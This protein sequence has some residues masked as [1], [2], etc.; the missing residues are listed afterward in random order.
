MAYTIRNG[1]LEKARQITKLTPAQKKVLKVS[2]TKQAAKI[3][4]IK[5]KIEEQKAS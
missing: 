4:E 1:K 3:R 5:A 2:T